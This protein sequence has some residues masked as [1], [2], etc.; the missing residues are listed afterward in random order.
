MPCAT[1][2]TRDPGLVTCDGPRRLGL[3][4]VLGG[5]GARRDTLAARATAARAHESS[6]GG[7]RRGGGGAA[8]GRRGG[9]AREAAAQ[10]RAAGPEL[11][12][13]LRLLPRPAW[14]VEARLRAD[15]LVAG[16]AAGR[17]P[18]GV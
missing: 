1:A 5:T 4:S 12:A 7:V 18:V 9:G 14:S 13:W 6:P 11:P 2:A 17:G 8:A 3:R 15:H 10:L 16:L